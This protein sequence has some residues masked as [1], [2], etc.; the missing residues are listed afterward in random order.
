LLGYTS[1]QLKEHLEKQFLY[2][3]NWDNYGK[4]H[5]DHKVPRAAL[6]YQSEADENF[7]KCWALENLQPLWAADNQ[8][9]GAKFP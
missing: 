2:G 8:K 7:K 5:I 6:P 3:M 4:W 9:K 1:Q